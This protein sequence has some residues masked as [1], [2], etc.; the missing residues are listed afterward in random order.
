M[1]LKVVPNHNLAQA[2]RELRPYLPAIDAALPV[3]ESSPDGVLVEVTDP[4]EHVKIAKK[5]GSIVV[6]VKE[7]E[8]IVHVAIPLEAALS[9]IHEIAAR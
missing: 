8:E 7:P 5:A 4:R 2:S 9:S 6:D 1:A 3:L